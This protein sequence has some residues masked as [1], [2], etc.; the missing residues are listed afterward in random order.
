MIAHTFRPSFSICFSS[1]VCMSANIISTVNSHCPWF[2]IKLYKIM[3]DEASNQSH[4]VSA[5]YD[6]HWDMNGKRKQVCVILSNVMLCAL[7]PLFYYYIEKCLVLI[8]T[9]VLPPLFLW[10]A[11]IT[12]SCM[13][14]NRTKNHH[15]HYYSFII[16]IIDEPSM[17]TLVN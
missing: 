16:I 10:I 2:M 7:S 14:C 1:G 4:H 11:V 12:C 13:V 6:K 3:F 8:F 5:V 17:N 15:R 9:F